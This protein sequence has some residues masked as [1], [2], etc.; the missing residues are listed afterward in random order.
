MIMDKVLVK[1]YVPIIEEQYD[2][3]LPLN[4]RVYSIINLLMKA[5]YEITGGYYKPDKIPILYDKLTGMPYDINLSIKNC[6]MSNGAEII[7]V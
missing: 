7:L 5:I 1:L 6:N 3:W 4:Q 2:V